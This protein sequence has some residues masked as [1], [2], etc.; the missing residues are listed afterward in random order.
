MLNRHSPHYRTVPAI[1]VACANRNRLEGLTFGEENEIIKCDQGDNDDA[2]RNKPC[3]ILGSHS[4]NYE[5]YHL[6]VCD[7][8]QSTRSSPTFR[9]K[10]LPSSSV[11]IVQSVR[12]SSTLRRNVLLHLQVRSAGCLLDLTLNMKAVLS[13]ET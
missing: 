1:L 2:E 8:L 6:L 7:D 12:S 10:I 13:S 11:S 4:G 5:E 3:W 9:R